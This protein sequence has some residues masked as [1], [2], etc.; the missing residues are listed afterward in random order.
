[1]EYVLQQF[2]EH[3]FEG[4]GKADRRKLA[5]E[6]TETADEQKKRLAKEQA[7]T[8]D[9]FAKRLAKRARKEDAAR[10]AKKSATA[11]AALAKADAASDK[12]MLGATPTTIP[13]LPGFSMNFD[14]GG[15]L[16]SDDGEE[17]FAPPPRK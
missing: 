3:T 5:L 9:A 14:Q 2:F 15:N 11:L 4:M 16:L 6:I 17:A 13:D 7:G 12:E 10:A 8:D 1:M